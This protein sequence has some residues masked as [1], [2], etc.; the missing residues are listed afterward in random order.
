VAERY[1]KTMAFYSAV[2]VKLN[3]WL[4]SDLSWMTHVILH[5][6]IVL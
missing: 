6:R 5:R 4:N 1:P 3:C 2:H